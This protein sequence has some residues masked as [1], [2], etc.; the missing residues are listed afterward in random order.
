MESTCTVD[1][2]TSH[3]VEL[4]CADGT[5]VLIREVEGE[6]I[7]FQ[8][9]PASVNLELFHIA[10]VVTGNASEL[11]LRDDAGTLL[12]AYKDKSNDDLS[13]TWAERLQPVSVSLTD[14]D[15]QEE[16]PVYCASCVSRTATFTE[17][18][19]ET[20]LL[21]GEQGLVGSAWTAVVS[22]NIDCEVECDAGEIR[23]LNLA[24]IHSSLL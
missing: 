15:C 20:L 18:G 13:P 2:Q 22:R 1:V 17:A 24:L 19:N 5:E 21:H 12:L 10:Q 16:V 9:L 14:S 6:V 4:S 11:V 8:M 23:P 3:R 7:N